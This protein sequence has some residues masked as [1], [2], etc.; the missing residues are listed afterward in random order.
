M[1]CNNISHLPGRLTR[2][3]M[4]AA[5]LLTAPLVSM[6]NLAAQAPARLIGTI[7]AI[8]AHALTVKPD[9]GDARPVDVPEAAIIK[10][11][12]PGEH[13]LSK[14][15]AISFA[16]LAIGDR[17][18]IK[19]DPNAPGS[20]LQI[21]A[22]RQQDLAAKQQKER[23]DWQKRGVGGLVKSV[24][25]A[26]G[27]LVVTSGSGNNAKTITIHT[28]KT[29][30]LKRYAPA[31]VNYEAA[32]PASID[33]I[34]PGDQL[35][36]RGEKSADGLSVAAEEVVSGTFRNISGVIASMDAADS[37]I[38][39]K[40][41]ATKK[42]VTLQI[43]AEAQMRRIPDR[44]AQMIAMRLKGGSAG[45]GSAAAGG[46]QASGGG[47]GRWSGQ[48]GNGQTGNG[49]WAGAPNGQSGA[50]ADP[51]Q[52]LSHMPAQQ[53]SDLKKGDAIMA[54]TT[55]GSGKVTVI[56][57]LAGV[58]PLLEAPAAQNLLSSWSMGSGGDSGQ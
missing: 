16:A 45:P 12:A 30:I 49:Q 1:N 3:A 31:S 32:Q 22:V 48:G 7:S 52:M 19:L 55:E 47:P 10:R 18:L 20:A 23:E 34:Q 5:L 33:A 24:D 57:L 25:A 53:F 42:Q 51:Q 37:T 50:A 29:T 46:A 56:T 2:R 44:I 58:E 43:P 4:L 27:V 17:V 9:A 21:I 14:A 38:T 54:V 36:A 11:I 35:R 40:D 39:L 28:T 6:R 13:D 15:E 26:A 41:L 8:S